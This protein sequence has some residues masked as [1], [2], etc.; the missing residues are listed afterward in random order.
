M[1]KFHCEMFGHF[2]YDESLTYEELQD[3]EVRLIGD[4]QITLEQRSAEHLD[5]TP[6]GDELMVQCAFEDYDTE[7]FREICEALYPALHPAVEARMLFVD[8]HMSSMLIFYLNHQECKENLLTLPKT[9]EA[10]AAPAPKKRGKT[11]AATT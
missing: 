3:M 8:K 9:H 5:F 10:L 2:I 4:V 7:L 6:L 11:K 1:N